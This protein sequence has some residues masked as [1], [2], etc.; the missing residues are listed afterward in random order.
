MRR[1]EHDGQKLGYRIKLRPGVPDPGA[2]F[3]IEL[4]IAELLAQPHPTYGKRRPIDDASVRAVLVAPPSKQKRGK[5]KAGWAASHKVIKLADAGS[6][7]VT[8][9][10]PEAGIYGLYLL[11][12]AG[13][14]GAI[15][16]SFPIAVGVWPVPKDPQFA[17]LPSPEPEAKTGDVDHGRA[18]CAARCRRDLPAASP[19]GE[20]PSFLAS[21]F[22][23]AKGD[24][25]LL[26]AVLKDAG[27]LSPVEK[28]NLVYFLRTLQLDVREFFPDAAVVLPHKFTINEYGR[29]RLKQC[30][31]Q[32]DD[33]TTSAV[34]F[35]VFRGKDAGSP[36]LIDY[37]DRVARD[38]LNTNDKLGYLM[39]L[40][41][42]GE[43]KVA[44]LGVAL[45]RE[46]TYPIIKLLARDSTGVRDAA[47]NKQLAAFTGQGK[48]NDTKSLKKGPHSLASK[49]L[50]VYLRAA[51]LATMY[52]GAERDFT[53]FDNEFK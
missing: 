46:P 21:E 29:D 4:E 2:T 24:A 27:G 37:E 3:T 32:L 40:S 7:A 26:A 50:P 23:A 33:A 49:L 25:A 8:F 43:K 5:A 18:L 16:Q 13:D 51:E 47:L 19:K 1:L 10:P 34:V 6:Y 22:A 45:G 12:D 31:I 17:A 48:F 15:E 44:E 14:V 28:A 9:T 41:L 36:Q 39:F 52:Y 38:R 20:V 11:G 42:P 35:T 30:G 53:A